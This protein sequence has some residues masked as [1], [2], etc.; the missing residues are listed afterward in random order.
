MNDTFDWIEKGTNLIEEN[1][2]AKAFTF[3]NKVIKK[4]P[5]NIDAWFLRSEVEFA[6][7]KYRQAFK[8]LKTVINLDPKHIKA[9]VNMGNTYRE[10]AGERR[11]K[12]IKTKGPRSLIHFKF[13]PNEIKLLNQSLKSYNQALIIEKNHENALMGKSGVLLSLEKYQETIET[14]DFLVEHHPKSKHYFH[15]LV[16]KANALK[17]I[18]EKSKAK[19]ILKKVKK[20]APKNSDTQKM[21]EMALK[22]L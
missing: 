10:L 16:G 18:N 1:K 22:Y 17:H 12:I 4:D 21:A 5:E 19:K 9:W 3:F 8:S 14:F 15:A 7:R 2:L 20:K 6:Q 11:E 13:S